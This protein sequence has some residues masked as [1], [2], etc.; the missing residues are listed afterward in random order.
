MENQYKLEIDEK[1]KKNG[2]WYKTDIHIT[3]LKTCNTWVY[4]S[5]FNFISP[6]LS[7]ARYT[8]LT[9]F[10]RGMNKNFSWNKV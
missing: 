1:N 10:R 8:A 3:I 6:S 9:K 5:L 7:N 4:I 2:Y